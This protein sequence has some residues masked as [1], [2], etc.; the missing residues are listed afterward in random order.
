ICLD[1]HAGVGTEGELRVNICE[2]PTMWQSQL[3]QLCIEHLEAAQQTMKMREQA[4]RNVADL[5]EA[6]MVFTSEGLARSSEYAAFLHTAI[7]E[8]LDRGPP[9][10][11]SVLR[12]VPI[13]V[14][15]TAPHGGVYRGEAVERDGEGAA[16]D[17]EA[18][19][20]SVCMRRA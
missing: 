5:L 15:P 20:Y 8:A 2:T 13:R 7:V 9:A 4:E 14:V 18:L 1:T 16:N 11:D 12:N 10:P 6:K 19:P 3:E 17:G